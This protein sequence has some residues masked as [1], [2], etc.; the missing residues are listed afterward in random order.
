[1]NHPIISIIVPV[2]K[3]EPYL[4]QCV[5]SLMHQTYPHLEIILV[6][7]GSPDNCGKI[8]DEYAAAD[9]RIKVIHQENQGVSAARNTALR[10]ATGKYVMFVDG[11]DW[12]D[13]NTCEI[14]FK[15]LS[16]YQADIVMWSYVREYGSHS[17]PKEIFPDDIVVFKTSDACNPLHRRFIGLIENELYHPENADA[18]CPVWGKLYRRET[19]C[20][21]FT[22]LNEIGTYEDGLFNLQIFAHVDT[23]V[24]INNPM[25]HYRKTNMGSATS[26]YNP[27]LFF[28]W[29][30]LFDLMNTYIVEHHLPKSYTEALNNRIALSLIGLGLN[31]ISANITAKSKVQ[32]IS[33]ILNAER[34]R[35]VYKQLQYQYFPL[36]WKVFF[37]C[38]KYRFSFGVYFL[39][40]AIRRIISK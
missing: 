4:H 19:I 17:S 33:N 28:Q 10:N 31:V 34:Y 36:H 13:T 15:T 20:T 39:L 27:Q 14:A 21:E 22:D 24:F 29:Q 35:G 9:S 8:C 1:M 6:D 2:Y 11:D 30:H 38:A 23:A 7:D 40:L 12:T 25:Y 37:I 26:A 18:L 3:V 32:K 5:D 16:Q